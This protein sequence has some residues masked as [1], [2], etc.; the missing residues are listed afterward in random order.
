[1]DARAGDSREVDTRVA[2]SN[3]ICYTV[4]DHVQTHVIGAKREV[5]YTREIVFDDSDTQE[6]NPYF[7]ASPAR[8]LPSYL[9]FQRNLYLLREG[10]ISGIKEGGFE[11]RF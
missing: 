3:H 5:A 10:Q 9:C 2:V 11:T 7:P 6:A 8:F 1:M 4:H